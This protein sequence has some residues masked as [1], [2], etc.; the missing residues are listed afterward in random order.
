MF[1]FRRLARRKINLI[2][3]III[4]PYF[5]LFLRLCQYHNPSTDSKSGVNIPEEVS[6]KEDDGN[7]QE[8]DSLPMGSVFEDVTQG[9]QDLMEEMIS[10]IVEHVIQGFRMLSKPYKKEK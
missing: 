1:I 7:S 2:T 5:Q 8:L 6:L 3:N 4:L 9:L 10:K